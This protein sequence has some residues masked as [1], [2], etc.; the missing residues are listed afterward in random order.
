MENTKERKKNRQGKYTVYRVIIY[1]YTDAER[2]RIIY[3]NREIYTNR[4][5]YLYESRHTIKA[6]DISY[7]T[8]RVYIN[9]HHVAYDINKVGESR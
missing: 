7:N 5:R 8:N 4:R 2:G 6:I 3:K 9:I 1:K